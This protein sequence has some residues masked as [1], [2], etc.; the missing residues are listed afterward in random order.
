MSDPCAAVASEHQGSSDAD[1]EP[2]R[3][4]ALDILVEDER[5]GTFAT[6]EEDIIRAAEVL[7]GHLKIEPFEA[8]VAL[9]SD[10]HVQ[11]LNSAYRGKDKPTNVLSFPAQS[12]PPPSSISNLSNQPPFLGDIILAFETVK[13]EAELESKPF[14]QHVQHLVVHGLLHLLGYD[15]ETDTEAGEMERHETEILGRLGVPDPYGETG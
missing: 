2:P 11:E 13:R 9:S 8:A 14:H 6:L 1:P 4:C 3:S 15:H 7:V 5:W 12:T 10:A